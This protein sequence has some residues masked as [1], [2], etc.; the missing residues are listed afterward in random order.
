MNTSP[1]SPLSQ[2]L[3]QPENSLPFESLAVIAGFE[4]LTSGLAEIALRYDTLIN[5][6]CKMKALWEWH[7]AEQIE[8]KTLAFDFLQV[9]DNGYWL[10]SSPKGRRNAYE[11]R[12]SPEGRR[13]STRLNFSPI[14][15]NQT[16]LDGMFLTPI[17]RE[18]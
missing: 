14:S 6:Y 12:A 17:R 11:E 1:L 9:I 13:V 15:L 3:A 10:R 4:H 8:H 2:R 5:A 16:V 18:T 7:A